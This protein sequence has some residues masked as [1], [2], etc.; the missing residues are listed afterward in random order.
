[1][2]T[3]KSPFIRR[4]SGVW[5]SLWSLRAALAEAN[6]RLAQRSIEVADLRLLCDELKSE[7]AA[8]RAEAVLARTEMQQRQ[9]ELGQVIGE[10]DQSRSQAVEAVGRAEA[11]RGQL[12][13]ATEQLAEA[14]A[15]AGTLAED[16]VVAVGSAQSAQAVASQERARAEGMFPPLCDLDSA[17][18]FNLCLKNFVRLSAEFETALN[19]SVKALAQ[20]AEQKEA[21]RVAM[22]EAISTVFRAFDL[23]DVPSGSSP[24]S[25]L[26]ALGGHV[27]GRLRG[28]LHHGV[29]RAFAV[30]ASHY[31]VDLER[32]S[33][34]YCLP[35]ED[36]AALAEV[37]RLAAAVAG[38]SAMLASSFE[39]EILP[40]ASPSEA[41]PDL[42]EGGNST[43]GAAPPP[44]DV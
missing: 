20:A 38:P 33:E 22:S 29:R 6:E 24:Q 27:R 18:F 12:A 4:E 34:G 14:S 31:N 9:L 25:H 11:L 17:S 40:L 15:R 3:A 35:D 28:A 44:A 37:Q 10:R 13:K 30:L 41:G 5:G 2:S 21:D 19:E 7:V 39:V 1:M 43:K 36:E 32:V 42:A 23:D 8:V 26:R 16:L